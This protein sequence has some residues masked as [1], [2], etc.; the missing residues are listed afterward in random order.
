MD[1]FFGLSSI[2]NDIEALEWLREPRNMLL[3]EL[4]IAEQQARKGG[5]RKTRDTHGFELNLME[6]L[7]NLRDSLWNYQYTPGRGTAHIIFRPVQREIFAAPY[8]DRIVQHWIVDMIDPWWEP[9]LDQ[10]S[11][12]CRVGKG[13]LYGVQRLRKY[14]LSLSENMT[15]DVFVIKMDITGYFMHIKRSLMYEKV[16]KGLDKQFAGNYGKRYEILK[17]AIHEVVFDDP[18]RDVKVQGSYEDWRGLPADK[19]LFWQEP[20]SGMVIG[21]LASQNFS[22]IYLDALDRFIHFDLGYRAHGRYV[23]DFYIVVTKEQL[24]KAKEDIR[25]IATFLNGI[26]LNMNWKKVRI[27][28]AWQGVPFLGMVV[29]GR[30]ILPGRRLMTNFNQSA[31]KL[32]GGI[33][34]PE[35]II[36]YLGLL[37]H[38]NG[39]RATKKIF[40][41]V[42]WEYNW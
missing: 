23:D 32:V 4:F 42:S 16:I 2:S 20:N 30:A 38:C 21:N 37:V 28:P 24:P 13:T 26:G 7:T 1:D 6:N 8:V 5:K 29:K 12:S 10:D 17:H 39:K 25:A 27:I 35:S 40:E 9:R 19:S 11:Y 14:I 31:Y 41:R 22:N 34:K 18:V 36:S 3:A 33:G 15:K